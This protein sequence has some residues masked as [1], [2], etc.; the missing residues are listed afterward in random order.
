VPDFS[1]TATAA[2]GG[3]L[4]AHDSYAPER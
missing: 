4:R 2:I 3:R 1:V